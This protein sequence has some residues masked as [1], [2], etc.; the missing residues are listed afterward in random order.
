MN[1]PEVPP[2]EILRKSFE[3]TR[4]FE[5]FISEWPSDVKWQTYKRTLEKPR[6]Q[7]PD[8]IRGV[9][10]LDRGMADSI[11][12]VDYCLGAPAWKV[13]EFLDGVLFQLT[14]DVFDSDCPQ[15]VEA[16]T[17]VMEYFGMDKWVNPAAG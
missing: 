10:Y 7:K 6:F 12:G 14:P 5:A 11:G 8:A 15:H 17:A 4:P 13:E 16:Q 2:V 9:H 1:A 3:I